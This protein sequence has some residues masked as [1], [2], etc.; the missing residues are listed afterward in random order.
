MKK[1]VW[2]ML[3]LAVGIFLSCS[4]PSKDSDQYRKAEFQYNKTLPVYLS[5]NLAQAEKE[6][7]SIIENYKFYTP[8]YIMLGKTYYF[9]N[10]RDEAKKYFGA[11]LKQG[12]NVISYIWMSKIALL[13]QDDKAA[14]K[15]LDQ[16]MKLDFSNPLTHYELAKYYRIKR[17]YEKAIYHYSFAISYQGMYKD[18]KYDLA[19]LYEELGL[20]DKALV[21]YKNILDED[22]V[23]T[24]MINEVKGKI[25]GLSQNEK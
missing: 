9:Q 10:K 12:P 13:D 8:A 22:G 16:A 5:G 14:F 18:M 23:S 11:S 6:F 19:S 17:E 3:I 1:R 15:Y 7:K 2:W 4:G 24:A 21:I 20:Q 25:K